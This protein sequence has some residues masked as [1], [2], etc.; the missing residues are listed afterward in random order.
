MPY[1][2]VGGASAYPLHPGVPIWGP[3]IQYVP[4]G[5]EASAPQKPW[6]EP[7]VR[8]R[9]VAIFIGVLIL[10]LI[11]MIPVLKACKL[12]W[13]PVYLILLGSQ[14]Y[15]NGIIAICLGAVFLFVVMIIVLFKC[16][17]PEKKTNQTVMMVVITV[18][19]L[20]GFFMLLLAMPFREDV[21]T[22]YTDLID[23]CNTSTHMQGLAN[24][25][26]SLAALRSNPSCIHR[27]SVELCDGFYVLQPYTKFLKDM[28]TKY[29]CGGFCGQAALVPTTPALSNAST[30]LFL[31][32]DRQW[33]GPID[34]VTKFRLEKRHA[35]TNPQHGRTL[36]T[37]MH[38]WVHQKGDQRS[39]QRLSH[40]SPQASVALA[41]ASPGKGSA[42]NDGVWED[43]FVKGRI[44]VQAKPST[45]SLMSMSRHSTHHAEEH[46]LQVQDERL[47]QKPHAVRPGELGPTTSQGLFTDGTYPGSCD[48]VMAVDLR[49]SAIKTAK[50]VYI[51]ALVI[52]AAAISLGIAKVIALAGHS[53]LKPKRETSLD[54]LSSVPFDADTNHVP[55]SITL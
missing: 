51:Q 20:Y 50:Y 13:N 53:Y 42:N 19:T 48:G 45:L 30:M 4:N 28:E 12:M 43:A 33:E 44:A 54:G 25:A 47:R 35:S 49:Y 5:Y 14:K 31:E 55:H 7:L 2:P 36:L 11:G 38:K 46:K 37:A 22:V 16:F 41:D 34:S 39:Q 9:R 23:A 29:R 3:P 26:A 40:I 15:P 10:S 17:R 18:L 21:Q 8:E 27:N 24:Y 52:L 32:P 6:D 1:P